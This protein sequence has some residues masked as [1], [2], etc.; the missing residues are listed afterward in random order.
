MTE[1]APYPPPQHVLR[2]LLITGTRLDDEARN[3]IPV[4]PGLCAVDG[5]RLGVLACMLDVTGARWPSPR[6]GPIGSTADLTASLIRPVR[7][8]TVE[9]VCRPLRVGVKSAVVDTT[10]VDDEGVTCGSGRMSF[11]R[12]RDRRPR[13]PSRRRSAPARCRSRSTAALP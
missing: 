4:H 1:R 3:T 11:A 7:A 9:I 8:G 6:S 13:P 12:I 5:V 2:D 10:L